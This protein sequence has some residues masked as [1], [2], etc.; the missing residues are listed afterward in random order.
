MLYNGHQKLLKLFFGSVSNKSV[1]NETKIKRQLRAKKAT[2]KKLIRKDL[3]KIPL[4]TIIA[5]PGIQF[6]ADEF[7][8][9]SALSSL[10]SDRY[11]KEVTWGQAWPLEAKEEGIELSL[12]F[13]QRIV[14]NASDNTWRL[15]TEDNLSLKEDEYELR[16]QAIGLLPYNQIVEIEEEGDPVFNFPIIHCQADELKNAF[17]KITAKIM[18]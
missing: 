8:L 3:D 12:P 14:F 4:E 16:S 11:S 1:S 6:I 18:N 15:Y 7:M 9:L 17:S 2:L 5:T 13:Y 10:S